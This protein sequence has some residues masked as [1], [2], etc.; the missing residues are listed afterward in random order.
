MIE[1]FR[2]HATRTQHGEPS[3][4]AVFVFAGQAIEQNVIRSVLP[5]I[6]RLDA[7]PAPAWSAGDPSQDVLWVALKTCVLAKKLANQT[8]PCLDVDL[9]GKNR[10]GTATLRAPSE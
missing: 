8:F 3:Y 9:G 5:L 4:A 2:F 10:L 1:P 7:L 6:L